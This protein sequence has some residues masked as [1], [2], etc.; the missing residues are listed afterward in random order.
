MLS[1]ATNS[2][3]LSCAYLGGS[4]NYYTLV[5]GEQFFKRSDDYLTPNEHLSLT[6]ASQI[7]LNSTLNNNTNNIMESLSISSLTM[8]QQQS[9][10]LS[11][12]IYSD[13]NIFLTS[14]GDKHNLSTNSSIDLLTALGEIL[15]RQ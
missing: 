1:L 3:I 12:L 5:Q 9:S 4:T 6:S 15:Q 10:T 8:M 14:F 13:L 11:S 2:N 7:S